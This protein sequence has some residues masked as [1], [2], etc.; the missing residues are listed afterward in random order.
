MPMHL[1]DVA[2]FLFGMGPRRK[3]LYQGRRLADA[4]TGE[5]LREW[6]V[7]RELIVPDAYT[8]HVETRGGLAIAIVEDEEAVW[9]HEGARREALSSG[10]VAL[11]S[12]EDH[13]HAR[14]LRVL[15]QEMLVNLVD[16]APVPNLFVYPKPW[17]RDAAMVCLCLER[18]GNL[19]LIRDWILALCDPFDRNNR[20]MRG[21]C[22]EP[23]NLG[24][25]LVMASMVAD[26]SHPI[27]QTV[28]DAVSRFRRGDHLAGRTDFAEHP[29]YQTKWLKWGLQRLGLEDP[30]RIPEI[31]D[32]YSS[33]FWMAYRDA[34]VSG[35]RFGAEARAKYPYLGWAEDHF[36]GDRP[37][38]PLS[39]RPY[40]L[41]WEAQA[42]QADYAPMA[43]VSNAYVERR[44]AAPHSWHAAEMFLYLLE[45][46]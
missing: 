4:R 5:V 33:L 19:R 29:V 10:R 34:H 27:V 20:D 8:V 7:A 45:V 26:A 16:G 21:P 28:L 41:T 13:R 43:V 44:L 17:H 14:A 35:P 46:E 15:H 38:T 39:D 1:P 12:F 18:T 24:Q 25:C 11:P 37:A 42:S 40:P 6:D 9:L 3:L 23:D 30:F 32:A 36:Y 31:H 22:E 2:F